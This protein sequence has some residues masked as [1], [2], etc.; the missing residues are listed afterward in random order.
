MASCSGGFSHS[1]TC[2]AR[3]LEQLSACLAF[4][5]RECLGDL[6]V[7]EVQVLRGNYVGRQYVDNVAERTQ[8]YTGA[9]EKLIELGLQLGEITRVI[10]TQL[11]CADR[12]DRTHVSYGRVLSN[13]REPLGVN[14]F[15]VPDAFEDRFMLEDFEVGHGSS[16]GDGVPGV[17]MAVKECFGPVGA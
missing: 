17:G 7:D 5:E 13:C 10:R 9:D 6:V 8:Q 11:D 2:E 12:S 3:L 15:D 16:C 1:E 4:H 14:E